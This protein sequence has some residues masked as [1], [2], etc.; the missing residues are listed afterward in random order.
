M[1]ETKE[2]TETID[3]IIPSYLLKLL[4]TVARREGFAEG[5]RIASTSGSNVGDGFIGLVLSVIISGTRTGI[6]D[7]ELVLI[8]KIPPSSELRQKLSV[9]PFQQEIAIYETFLPAFV[10]FQQ[11]KGISESD[12]FFAFPKCYGT[13]ADEA[14]QE[15]A[16]VLEDLRQRGFRLWNKFSPIDYQ[17]VKLAFTQLGKFHAVSFA[18]RQQRPDIFGQIKSMGSILMNMMNDLPQFAEYYEA[19]FDSAIKALHPEDHEEISKITH[20]R[21]NFQALFRSSVSGSEAEP[22]SVLCHGDF[23]TNNMMFQ[24][25]SDDSLEPQSVCVIDWQITQYSSP[26]TD[27]AFYIY[28]SL[29]QP[30]RTAHFD[31]ILHDYH[32]N[33]ADL[34]QRLGGNPVAQFSFDVLQSQLKEFGIFG[35]TMA[36]VQIQIMTVNDED[37]PD[38][39][40]LTMDNAEGFDFMAN[41]S[42]EAYNVRMRDVIRDFVR[43]G[44]FGEQ[45][46]ALTNEAEHRK[47]KI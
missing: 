28:S 18:L 1:T 45:H 20:L 22:F 31:D 26:A 33:L 3:L 12:G 23:W 27:V 2:Q 6:A 35:L 4:E 34:L 25:N 36:P 46:L 37:I 39:D 32:D 11:A 10:K 47:S 43:R 41:S 7:Q 44:Y 5:F 24:Y 14:K 17:H 42:L 19:S 13:H 30:L 16:I 38:M 21:N 40:A 9:I 8:C 29:E 15:F